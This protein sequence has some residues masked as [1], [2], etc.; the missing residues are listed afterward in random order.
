M[1]HVFRFLGQSLDDKLWIISEKDE[2]HHLKH[3]VKLKCGDI[4]E[5]TNGK[6]LWAKGYI[7]D[8][9]NNKIIVEVESIYKDD[10]NLVNFTIAIGM[11]RYNSLDNI[12]PSLIE[13]GISNICVFAQKGLDLIMYKDKLEKR[14]YNI[15]RVAIKQSKQSYLPNIIIYRDLNSIVFNSENIFL[16]KFFCDITS[17][18]HINSISFV[19]G[20][21]IVLIGSEAGFDNDEVSVLKNNNYIAIKLANNVLRTFTATLCAAYVFSLKMY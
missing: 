16:N 11:I 10:L 2:I 17:E 19:K 4:I 7:C 20:Q 5:I 13:L 14:W 21:T 9:K 12:L 1:R 6:G 15:A 3:V 8:I 18:Q